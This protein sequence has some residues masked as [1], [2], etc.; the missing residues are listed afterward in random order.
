MVAK[1]CF[2]LRFDVDRKQ[3]LRTFYKDAQENSKF[4]IGKRSKK[5]WLDPNTTFV[6]CFFLFLNRYALTSVNVISNILPFVNDG[7]IDMNANLM[8]FCLEG[9]KVQSSASFASFSPAE[10]FKI[11]RSR[12]DNISVLMKGDLIL[13]FDLVCLNWSAYDY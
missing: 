4:R 3:K 12:K 11:S 1:F 13:D 2:N 7:I 9:N 6:L 5:I 10:F 8:I